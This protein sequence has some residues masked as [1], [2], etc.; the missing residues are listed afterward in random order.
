MDSGGFSDPSS[1]WFWDLNAS[2][3]DPINPNQQA[4]ASCDQS[5]AVSTVNSQ[6]EPEPWQS[7]SGPNVP[8]ERQWVPL[9]QA[10]LPTPRISPLS[11]VSPGHFNTSSWY[12]D[13]GYKTLSDPFSFRD[14]SQNVLEKWQASMPFTSQLAQYPPTPNTTPKPLSSGEL[15]A[16]I[17]LRG[18]FPDGPE[19]QPVKD[20]L[21]PQTIQQPS[22]SNFVSMS[23]KSCDKQP[24]F[25][26]PRGPT[27][28]PFEPLSLQAKFSHLKDSHHQDER[29]YRPRA[30]FED[31]PNTVI[32][33]AT[34]AAE[35][36]KPVQQCTRDLSIQVPVIGPWGQEEVIAF[37]TTEVKIIY[38]LIY[39]IKDMRGQQLSDE[40]VHAVV[41][42]WRGN[43]VHHAPTNVVIEALKLRTFAQTEAVEESLAKE[44]QSW[45]FKAYRIYNS[46]L[47]NLN[48]PGMMLQSPM[49]VNN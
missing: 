5:P 18:C 15:P 34:K 14:R 25:T 3:D 45:Y 8:D 46:A 31:A 7:F 49:D 36:S 37:S 20:Q 32:S 27:Q 23:T 39:H 22:P 10:K 4:T 26:N 12:C 43:P 35:G 29:E 38:L 30:H 40:T 2:L 11:L 16:F 9:K 28:P 19:I 47:C 6:Q 1:P 44:M 21:S 13:T 48:L 24:V 41:Q 42:F 33:N 17:D